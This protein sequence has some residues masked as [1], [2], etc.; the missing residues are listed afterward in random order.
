MND[1][2]ANEN[3]SKGGMA[4]WRWPLHWQILLGLILGAA[5]GYGIGA[6]AVGQLPEDTYPTIAGAQASKIATESYA[7]L[8]FDLVGDLFIQ[9][10]KLIIVPLVMSS[11]V[12]AV[13]NLG[14]GDH[15]TGFGRLTGKTMGYY[16]ATSV[17][18]VV[19]GLVVVNAGFNAQHGNNRQT[20]N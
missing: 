13:A 4:P 20:Q 1:V 19:I 18:S 10:L 14:G 17:I 7:Y 3:Q 16:A 8:F 5:V 9:G 15:R 11:I 6:W 2:I 12:L